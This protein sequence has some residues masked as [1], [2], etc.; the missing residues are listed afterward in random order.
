MYYL[1]NWE[2]LKPD[3]PQ[4]QTR[5]EWLYRYGAF[6]RYNGLWFPCRVMGFTTIG[7]PAQV[8]TIPIATMNQ[9]IY[10]QGAVN[11]KDLDV[12]Y[13]VFNDG[14]SI[15]VYIQGAQK[16]K[17]ITNV[18]LD[19][20]LRKSLDT[21]LITAPTRLMQQIKTAVNKLWKGELHVINNAV[22]DDINVIELPRTA[23]ILEKLWNSNDWA[24]Q[25]ISQLLGISFN[26]SHGKKERML[27][28]E[29][30]GDRDLTIMNREKIT[31]RL[32]TSAEKFG[33][34]VSH[35]STHVDTIDR[36]LSYGKEKI[37]IEEKEVE[38]I[39]V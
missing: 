23:E 19:G 38:E 21:S 29:M 2:D 14:M 30:L 17:M 31:T 28:N 35:I 7:E 33:E 6:A 24:L 32:I 22:K 37:G 15:E 36:G 16:R 26:P 20:A 25:E 8:L 12:L 13:S 3:S 39:E 34:K 9:S 4:A 27:Q 10:P 11:A 18:M 1:Y 5:N